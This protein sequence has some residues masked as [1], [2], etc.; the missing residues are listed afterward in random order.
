MHVPRQVHFD[1]IYKILRHLK[2]SPGKGLLFQK[3]GHLQG[4]AYTD[5]NW[6][7]SLV[8][9]CSTSGYCTSVGGNLVTW[10]HKKQM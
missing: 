4:E 8:D 9:R 7:G 10:R 5:G 1:A 2:G 3:H 6:D